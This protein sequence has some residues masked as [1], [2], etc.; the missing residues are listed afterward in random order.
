[1]ALFLG[2]KVT[3]QGCITHAWGL[4]GWLTAYRCCRGTHF[5]KARA[6]DHCLG[7]LQPCNPFFP[8]LGTREDSCHGW[9]CTV[10]KTAGFPAG[11]LTFPS[12]YWCSPESLHGGTAGINTL[13]QEHVCERRK[14]HSSPQHH[15][16]TST[17]VGRALICSQ[18]PGRQKEHEKELEFTVHFEP[19]REIFYRKECPRL[20]YIFCFISQAGEAAGRS[21]GHTVVPGTWFSAAWRFTWDNSYKWQQTTS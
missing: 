16:L 4:R 7:S 14:C 1:M 9:F 19:S 5:R 6:V 11:W 18:G 8:G 12:I 3:A 20:Q 21:Y 10:T 13:P 2:R 17:K 15:R